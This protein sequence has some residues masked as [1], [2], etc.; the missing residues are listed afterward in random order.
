MPAMVKIDDE[1]RGI[2]A[3]MSIE[4]V[5]A[6]LPPGQLARPVYEKVNKALTAL[7]GKWNRGKGGHVFPSDPTPLLRAGVDSGAVENLKQKYQFFETPAD[8]AADMVARLRLA[9]RERVLEPSAGRGRLVDPCL[10]AGAHVYAVEIWDQNTPHLVAMLGSDGVREADF[11]ALQPEGR[12]YDAVVMNPP[13]T[14]KQAIQHIR[15][16][17]TWLR[18]GGRMAAIC[19]SGAMVNGSYAEQG[20]RAWLESIGAET[21]ELPAGTFAES[22]TGVRS[23]LIVATKA[24]ALD[25]RRVA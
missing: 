6:K 8:L 22:G 17:W 19:D 4:G 16:A 3:S 2:L 21:E 10:R 7:G 25:A 18:P 13:F 14:K 9:P 11:L 15:H 12:E 20:F 1:T 23:M 24:A 5:V